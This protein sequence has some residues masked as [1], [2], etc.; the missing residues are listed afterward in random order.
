MQLAIC[1]ERKTAKIKRWKRILP[2]GGKK[3][4]DKADKDVS[5]GR[6]KIIKKKS[7]TAGKAVTAVPLWSWPPYEEMEEECRLK[8]KGL[9]IGPWLHIP[10]REPHSGNCSVHKKQWGV[11]TLFISVQEIH[12][13]GWG[14][15]R[16]EGRGRESKFWRESFCVCVC[17]SASA[18]AKTRI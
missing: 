4:W 16:G 6:N 11:S 15:G 18:A 14:R 8:G 9:G 7:A 2:W 10:Q 12:W 13:A 3:C 5:W 1:T 17:S